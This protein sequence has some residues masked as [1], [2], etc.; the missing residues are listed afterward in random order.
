MRD[1][2]NWVIDSVVKIQRT[3]GAPK[4]KLPGGL[5]GRWGSRGLEDGENLVR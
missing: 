4:E 5:M 2:R 1:K 3:I